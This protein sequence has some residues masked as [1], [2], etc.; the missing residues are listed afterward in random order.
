MAKK[1]NTPMV[2]TI[3]LFLVLP[4]ELLAFQTPGKSVKHG[5]GSGI[6]KK[7]FSR[8]SSQPPPQRRAGTTMLGLP[9]PSTISKNSRNLEDVVPLSRRG[10]P[11]NNDT[12][13]FDTTLATIIATSSNSDTV[14]LP[15]SSIEAAEELGK[16]IF[17]ENAA[18]NVEMTKALAAQDEDAG[19]IDAVVILQ[20]DDLPAAV[21]D[22]GEEPPMTFS[23]AEISSSLP[24][25]MI[26]ATIEEQQVEDVT[27]V[28]QLSQEAAADATPP[29]APSVAKILQFA[30]PAIGV[31]LCNPLLSMIDTAAVGLFSGTIQQAALNPAVAVTDY[32]ALLIA[33]LYTGT[34]NLVA[35]AWEQ[36]KHKTS[37]RT[38]E[39]LLGVMRL[40]LYVGAGLGAVLFFGAP[41]LVRSMIGGEAVAAASPAV[42]KAAIDYVRIRALGMP[43]AAFIGSTQAA[44]LGMQDIKSPLY[45]LAAAALVNFVCDMLTVKSMGAAGVAWATVASQ[46]AG[47]GLFLLWLRSKRPVV[48][49]SKAILDMNTET[50]SK[51]M[52]SKP[53]N[54]SFSVRGFLHGKLR[55]SD[56]IKPPSRQTLD[57]FSEYLVPVTAT[58]VGR[59]SGYVAMSHVVSSSLGTASMAAQQI[60]VSLFYCLTPIGDSLSLTAQSFV[61]AIFEKKNNSTQRAQ[62][63]RQTIVNFAKAGGI[64]GALMMVAIGSI[65]I[66]SR[67]FTSDLSVIGRVNTVTPLL[68]AIVSVHGIVCATEGLLLGQKDLGFLGKLYGSFFAIVPFFMLRLKT[69]AGANL[70]SVWTVFLAYQLARCAVWTARVALLQRKTDQAAVAAA[71]STK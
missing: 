42:F 31:W 6:G 55:L 43:A 22:G 12:V 15:L 50:L 52:N 25:I 35:T 48:N 62:A 38:A 13:N 40:S 8:T 7:R 61:P 47:M 27:A 4:G 71:T 41:V 14:V 3:M 59:V 10:S 33:F 54:K 60:I 39:T 57:Q 19:F 56:L 46:M 20:N 18:K 5:G 49:V 9:A 26:E 63:L 23:S 11:G 53:K 68:A 37:N 29:M 2:A 21:D 51:A 69:V 30:I 36:D 17:L 1:K 66:V 67:A 44:C 65:P 24:S 58:Q 34:T 16:A 45:V 70:T 64:F 32:T 28:W